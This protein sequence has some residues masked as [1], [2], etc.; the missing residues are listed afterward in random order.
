MC[1]SVQRIPEHTAIIGHE[2]PSGETT[3][4]G[5]PRSAAVC[6]DFIQLEGLLALARAWGFE[7]PLSHQALVQRFGVRCALGRGHI[8]WWGL[9]VCPVQATS[10]KTRAYCTVSPLPNGC[11][12]AAAA[13][14]SLRPTMWH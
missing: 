4:P 11:A 1:N 10:A 5:F 7:S 3:D 14:P 6:L 12:S 9:L 13:S 8:G 2:P